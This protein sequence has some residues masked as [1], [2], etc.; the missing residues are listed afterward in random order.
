MQL[1]VEGAAAADELVLG[2]LPVFQLALQLGHLL[3]LDPPDVRERL[4]L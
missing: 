2:D 4:A 1:R 3:R